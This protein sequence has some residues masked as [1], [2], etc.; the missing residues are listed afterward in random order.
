[1]LVTVLIAKATN[2]HVTKGAGSAI[3]LLRIILDIGRR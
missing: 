3:R 2:T 1:M